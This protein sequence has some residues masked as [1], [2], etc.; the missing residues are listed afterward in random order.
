MSQFWQFR[1]R[2]PHPEVAIEKTLVLGRKWN[3][4]FFSIGSS[5]NEQ[6]LP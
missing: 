1:H 6:G 2:K 5:W 3:R 4:G